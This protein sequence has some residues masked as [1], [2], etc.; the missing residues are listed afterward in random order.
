MRGEPSTLELAYHLDARAE[1]L[2]AVGAW[3]LGALLFA[4][5]H[6]WTRTLSRGL[7]AASRVGAER[8]YRLLL[9]QLDR[10]STWLHEKEVRDL[11]DRVASV[12]VPTGLLGLAVLGVTP[13]R[14]RFQVGTVG[15]A[16]VTLVMALAFA[17]AA[18][19]ATLRAKGHLRL[20]LLISCVGFSLAMV[21]AL[22]AAP[23]VALT[24]VLVETTFTLLFAG[25]LALL[26][27]DRLERAQHEA[28]HPRG[29]DRLAAA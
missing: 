19:L 8:G 5:R 16:D 3:A 27:R 13:L 9:H 6:A 17:S 4:T 1:N 11:R 12:L 18:A 10:L 22:A 2:L 20:V 15:W 24:S 28:Q 25:L 26:P 23:D 21:F 7:A 29:R 14:D